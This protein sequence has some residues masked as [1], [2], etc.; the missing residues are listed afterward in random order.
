MRFCFILQFTGT[1]RAALTVVCLQCHTKA[2]DPDTN[3]RHGPRRSHG[4][5]DSESRCACPSYGLGDEFK[6]A[7]V[8]RSGLG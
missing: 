1:V 7:A 5:R 4:Y 2:M 3:G 8:Y 6:M